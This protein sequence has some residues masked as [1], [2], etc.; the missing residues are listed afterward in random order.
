[1]DIDKGYIIKSEEVSEFQIRIMT[2]VSDW[3]KNKKTTVPKKE[4]IRVMRNDGVKD[5]TTVNA[6]MS[7]VKKGYI[8]KSYQSGNR[9]CYVQLR[10]LSN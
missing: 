3:V 1:M 4:I 10:G 9:V 8:R 7:L 5:F 2:F 6:L